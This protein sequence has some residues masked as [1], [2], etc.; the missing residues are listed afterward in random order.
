[1]ECICEF[2]GTLFLYGSHLHSCLDSNHKCIQK[3]QALCSLLTLIPCLFFMQFSVVGTSLECFETGFEKV[4]PLR[5][6]SGCFDCEF[7]AS[8]EE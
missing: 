4:L 6:E 2:L 3:E 5:I 7:G 8:S 1:M